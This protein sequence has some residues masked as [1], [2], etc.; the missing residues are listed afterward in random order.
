[1]LMPTTLY[2]S[3]DQYFRGWFVL[4]NDPATDVRKLIKYNTGI[5]VNTYLDPEC[6]GSHTVVIHE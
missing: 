6:C 4:A 2:A 1:M 5:I 3:M